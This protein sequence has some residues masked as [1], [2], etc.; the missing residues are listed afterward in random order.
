MLVPDAVAVVDQVPE[1]SRLEEL[2]DVRDFGHPERRTLVNTEAFKRGGIVA[3]LRE[4][5]L[6]IKTL[7][8]SRPLVFGRMARSAPV[9]RSFGRSPSGSS[10]PAA[11]R[12]P[13]SAP[14]GSACASAPPRGRC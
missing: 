4:P 5:Q 3:E 1:G 8:P 11:S 7:G 10:R 6:Q 2:R 14:A 12:V 13:T 9:P